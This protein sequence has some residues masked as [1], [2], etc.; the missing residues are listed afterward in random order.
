MGRFPIGADAFKTAVTGSSEQ[1]RPGY[2]DRVPVCPS[3]SIHPIQCS[4]MNNLHINLENRGGK[5]SRTRCR[6]RNPT[7]KSQ[8]D[9]R[10]DD[11]RILKIAVSQWGAVNSIDK[12]L[13]GREIYEL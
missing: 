4:I 6:L 5:L 12:V 9:K 7:E 13:Q 11:F 2:R 1:Q 3:M 8:K 10:A